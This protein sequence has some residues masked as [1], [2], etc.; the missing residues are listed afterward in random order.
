MIYN[1]CWGCLEPSLCIT[2]CVVHSSLGR[3]GAVEPG[4]PPVQVSGWGRWDLQGKPER[5]FPLLF[6]LPLLWP[7]PHTQP[8]QPS[9]I[10][11]QRKACTPSFLDLSCC[12]ERGVQKW[13]AGPTWAGHLSHILWSSAALSWFTQQCCWDCGIRCPV[14]L[15]LQCLSSWSLGMLSNFCYYRRKTLSYLI[16]IPLLSMTSQRSP[17]R[18]LW[19]RH[20]DKQRPVWS[21]DRCHLGW[22][23]CMGLWNLGQITA[24]FLTC[25]LGVRKPKFSESL[26]D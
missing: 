24:Y 4:F 2:K 19:E 22:Q 14:P 16:Q 8:Q 15:P 12:K 7:P 13:G 9:R 10:G 23:L 18:E 25:K 21:T 6:P 5:A 11:Y 20:L 17:R 3:D 1:K 26:N